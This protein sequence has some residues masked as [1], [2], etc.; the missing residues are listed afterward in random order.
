[1][2]RCDLRRPADCAAMKQFLMI[3]KFRAAAFAVATFAFAGAALL[4][5]PVQAQGAAVAMPTVSPSSTMPR[6]VP[7]PRQ[8][9]STTSRPPGR[10]RRSRSMRWSQI[11]PADETA[12]A[13][14]DCLA[15]AV[16]FEARGEPLQRPARGR[17][18]GD[19][20]RRLGP[21]SG[22]P[23]RRRRPAAR[24]SPSSAAAASR[25]P[26]GLG[27]LAPRGRRRQGRRRAHGA[28]AAAADCLWYHANYVSP[29]WG[30][31]LAETTRIGL[32]IFYS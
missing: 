10:P 30:H 9:A 11:R 14:Q 17:R 3:T 19:E 12:D 26:T 13:E 2:G 28:A 22:E 23:V 6:S 16:Y 25:R 31:R 5:G 29:S 7:R 18:S 4:G 27:R 8:S 20:P 32:H 1:M 24:N 21:L 15:N